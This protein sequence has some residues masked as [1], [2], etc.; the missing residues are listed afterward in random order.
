MCKERKFKIGDKVK[1]VAGSPKGRNGVVIAIVGDEFPYGVEFDKSFNG[2]GLCGSLVA[3]NG[4]WC[5][6][7]QLEYDIGFK[8]G[9]K[10]RYNGILQMLNNCVGTIVYIENYDN[11]AVAFENFEGHTCSG[12]TP[13]HN[14]WWCLSG[15]LEL[16]KEDDFKDCTEDTIRDPENGALCEC[17]VPCEFTSK[18]PITPP[19]LTYYDEHYEGAIQPI[20]LM[21]LIMTPEEFKGFLKGNII[22]YTMRCGKKDDPEK[23]F[24]KIRRYKQ[25]LDLAE[26]GITIDP[27][28]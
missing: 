4:A 19:S 3:E 5:D 24:V 2:V 14:G 28:M 10:V 6:E 7:T 20:E 16:I 23:E 27:R 12:H 15:E 22:K 25:W 11:C 1:C 13:T 17:Q 21:Q 9:D 18:E 26:Q 8:V